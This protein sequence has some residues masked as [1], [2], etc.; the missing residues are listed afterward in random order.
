MF[1]QELKEKQ[2]WLSLIHGGLIINLIK[3]LENNKVS[4]L[5]FLNEQKILYEL[6]KNLTQIR[7]KNSLFPLGN[8][9]LPDFELYITYN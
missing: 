9:F 6:T 8:N 4:K 5:L 1:F 3:G 7:N 2:T